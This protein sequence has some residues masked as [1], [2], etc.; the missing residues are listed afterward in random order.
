MQDGSKI[1]SKFPMHD[2]VYFPIAK[3]MSTEYTEHENVCF[4]FSRWYSTGVI[5]GSQMG[6]QMGSQLLQNSEII[7][8]TDVLLWKIWIR[9]GSVPYLFSRTYH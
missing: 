4:L 7:K 1:S 9:Y 8:Q 2:N 3:D 5:S 6:S